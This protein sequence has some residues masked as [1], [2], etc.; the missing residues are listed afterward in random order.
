M[1]NSYTTL[2]NRKGI[3]NLSGKWAHKILWNEHLDLI[4]EAV[5]IIIIILL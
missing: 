3:F 4:I 2:P 5:I 1:I